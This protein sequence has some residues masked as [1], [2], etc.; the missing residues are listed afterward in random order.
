MVVDVLR[1]ATKIMAEVIDEHELGDDAAYAVTDSLESIAH[2]Y[3]GLP[4]VGAFVTGRCALGHFLEELEDLA[5][6]RGD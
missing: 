5:S 1:R 6:S 2:E 3:L 4:R